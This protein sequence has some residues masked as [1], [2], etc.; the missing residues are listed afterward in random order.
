MSSLT[1]DDVAHLAMLA[2]IDLDDAEL[3]RMVGELDVILGA[4]AKVQQAPIDGVAPMSHP[5]PLTNVT[6]PDVLRAGLTPAEALSGA[7]EVHEQRFSVP[8]I[9]TE[10]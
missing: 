4:V 2:R 3:D 5:L 10:D 7:P 9:L 1:R 6:R 8:R